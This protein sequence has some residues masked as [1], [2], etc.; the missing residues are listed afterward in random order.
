MPTRLIDFDALWSSDKLFSCPVEARR[1]YA[2]LYGLADA[3][4]SFELTNLR[5]IHG[6]VA[7]IRED[8]SLEMLV[9]FFNDYNSHGLLFTWEQGG[10]QYG[11]WTNCDERLPPKSLRDRYARLAPPVPERE[12]QEYLSRFSSSTP[13][14]VKTA[15][16]VGLEVALTGGGSGLGVGS[17][18]SSEPVGS[19]GQVSKPNPR[20]EASPEGIELAQLLRRLILANNP[21]AKVKDRRW[22]LQADRMMRL[23]N[24]TPAEVREMIEFSQADSF[25]HKNILCMDTL[26]GKFDT[27]TLKSKGSAKQDPVSVPVLAP[28][29]RNDLNDAGR[30]VYEK[31]G[32]A[33][34]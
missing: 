3:H 25:W 6:R 13:E 8:L 10:K 31:A 17:T 22:A 9:Q 29:L 2:W 21:K 23:D 15:S 30:A 11:H 34:P 26:R 32:V 12:L 1:E 20:K 4:G 19:D 16:R 14:L 5:V 33:M 28:R 24:R 7:P 27:L 18:S